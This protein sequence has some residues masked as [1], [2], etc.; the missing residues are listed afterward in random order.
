MSRTGAV[1]KNAR[2]SHCVTAQVLCQS[3]CVC[4]CE[5]E[6]ESAFIHT[7][8]ACVRA[9]VRL[10]VSLSHAT[11]PPPHAHSCKSQQ[12]RTAPPSASDQPCPPAT[13]TSC[14]GRCVMAA[15]GNSRVRVMYHVSIQLPWQ[16]RLPLSHADVLCMMIHGGRRERA[17]TATTATHSC[18]QK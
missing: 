6:R 7:H 18:C 13:P 12:G 1:L 5:R 3:R 14:P 10:S 16:V 11:S 8:C 15:A 17:T 2:C 4:V 9:C